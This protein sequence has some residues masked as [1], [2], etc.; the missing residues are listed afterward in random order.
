MET[1]CHKQLIFESLCGRE[2]VADFAGGPDHLRCHPGPRKV[3]VLD[4]D[5]TDD[6]THGRQ[7]LSFFHDYYAEHSLKRRSSAP[8]L[9]KRASDGWINRFSSMFNIGPLKQCLNNAK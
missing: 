9:I 6:P 3:I 2:V 7:Q 4:M 1:V 8:P 5:G